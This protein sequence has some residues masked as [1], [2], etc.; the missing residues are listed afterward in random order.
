MTM[1]RNSNRVSEVKYK[2]FV[3]Q[4]VRHL[5]EKE[6]CQ[7]PG[8]AGRLFLHENQ[9]D[10]WSRGLSFAMKMS[11]GPDVRET[12]SELCRS[13]LAMWS[14]RTGSCFKSKSEYVTEELSMCCCNKD[15]RTET[16]VKNVMLKV[17]RGLKRESHGVD[18][19]EGPGIWLTPRYVTFT[20]SE[21]TIGSRE[22]DRV[23]EES[24]VMDSI[25]L[26][27]CCE[28]RDRWRSIS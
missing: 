8:N 1:M 4:C 2:N 11:E 5:E 25:N 6:V 28:N 17:F 27:E 14:S 7:V 10:R 23:G 19:C 24:N 26:V 12:Q 9:W 15:E 22:V 18:V 20:D 21:S 3:E 13:Q 16:H